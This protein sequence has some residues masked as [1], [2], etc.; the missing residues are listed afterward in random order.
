MIKLELWI[1][2]GLAKY[3]KESEEYKRNDQ[4]KEDI[5]VCFHEIIKKS[6]DISIHRIYFKDHFVVT[7]T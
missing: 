3:K 2:P 1:R 5:I 7:K 4:L 6:T